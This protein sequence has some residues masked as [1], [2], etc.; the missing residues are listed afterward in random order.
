MVLVVGAL[1]FVCGKTGFT[2]DVTPACPIDSR[3]VRFFY[4]GLLKELFA[5]KR[6]PGVCFRSALN[7]PENVLL[8]HA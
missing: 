1:K 6:Y 8:V 2:E 7:L 3:P 4:P 5:T